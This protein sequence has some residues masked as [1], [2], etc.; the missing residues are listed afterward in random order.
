MVYESG[1][2][3]LIGTTV[4]GVVKRIHMRTTNSRLLD[5]NQLTKVIINLE[6]SRN[7]ALDA[8]RSPWRIKEDVVMNHLG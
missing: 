1:S 5:L 7:T 2:P 8:E 3:V 4:S 6:Y